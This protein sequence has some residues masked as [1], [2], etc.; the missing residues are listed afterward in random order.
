MSRRSKFL[1]TWK[2]LP[3]QLRKVIVSVIGFTLITLGLL[4]IVLPGP[5]TLPFLIL[6]LVVLGLEF[7]WAD[8]MLDQVKAQGKKVDPR[9]LLKRKPKNPEPN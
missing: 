1:A 2:T 3:R 4:L 9:K 5:F 8:R 7:A 6:G